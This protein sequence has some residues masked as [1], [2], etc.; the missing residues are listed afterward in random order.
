MR[1]RKDI[2]FARL[3]GFETVSEQ[4]S[5]RLDFQDADIGAKLGAKV[6]V[7]AGDSPVKAVET[8][9]R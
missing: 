5:G 6:G 2:D 4:L 9:A 3:L 8:M 1:E 7:E